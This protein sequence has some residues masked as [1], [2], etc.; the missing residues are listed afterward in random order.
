[1]T[2]Q[3][4][5]SISA[6]VSFFYGGPHVSSNTKSLKKKQNHDEQTEHESASLTLCD[7]T[8]DTRIEKER[9]DKKCDDDD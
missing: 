2:S 4:R 8:M 7:L 5:V 6:R 1:M 9:N 3:L